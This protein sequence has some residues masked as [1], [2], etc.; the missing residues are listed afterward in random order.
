MNYEGFSW[1]SLGLPVSGD[2]SGEEEF[3]IL[4]HNQVKWLHKEVKQE[5]LQNTLDLMSESGWVLQDVAYKHETGTYLL[6]SHQ[7]CS[8]VVSKVPVKYKGGEIKGPGQPF[9]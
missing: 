8:V 7:V 9:E 3:C 4:R 1:N 6:L 5:N 2:S